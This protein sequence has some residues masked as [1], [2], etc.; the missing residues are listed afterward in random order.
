MKKIVLTILILF[1][2]VCVNAQQKIK[3]T[4][5]IG[6]KAQRNFRTDKVLGYVYDSTLR[7]YLLGG[8][9]VEVC[10]KEQWERKGSINVPA[11]IIWR[12]KKYRIVRLKECAFENY[13]YVDS[14][15][16]PTSIKE[17]PPTCFRC[18]SNLK[19]VYMPSVTKIE[20]GS[21]YRT[22]IEKLVI[23]RQITY[24]GS[25]A[26][27]ECRDLK[28]IEF[29]DTELTLQDNAFNGARI[30]SVKVKYPHPIA[31]NW[32]S[33]WLDQGSN[34]PKRQIT[35]LCP[36]GTAGEYRNDDNWQYFR[37]FAEYE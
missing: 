34:Y 29:P 6:G 28:Y 12:N 31:F 21:F 8:D 33:I 14:V 19:Y 4:Q 2:A 20:A 15:F 18:C 5:Y 25:Y 27:C 36:K 9:S 30:D 26:F 32:K 35:L 7:Y 13:W 3:D 11:T 24:I 17:I 16:L 23:P 1:C 37:T 10:G 22:D